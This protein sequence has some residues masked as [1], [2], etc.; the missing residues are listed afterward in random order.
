[1]IK[2]L[3]VLSTCAALSLSAASYGNVPGSN[4]AGSVIV[5]PKLLR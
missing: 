4:D 2:S 3:R 1:M 5:S